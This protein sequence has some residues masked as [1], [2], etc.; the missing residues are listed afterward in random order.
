MKAVLCSNCKHYLA[1]EQICKKRHSQSYGSLNCAAYVEAQIEPKKFDNFGTKDQKNRLDLLPFRA[2]E[3]VG[4]IMTYGSIKYGANSWQDLP[5]F[6]D[7]YKGALLRHLFKYLQGET[8]DKESGFSHL[9]HLATNAL[10]LLD[11]EGVVDD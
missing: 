10:F 5:N 11:K 1:G 8:I 6:E 4:E 9:Q 7:R 3:K 2:L